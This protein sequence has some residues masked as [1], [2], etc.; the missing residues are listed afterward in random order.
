MI[1]KEV[2]LWT[3]YSVDSISNV[4]M[5]VER[6]K[7]ARV[8]PVRIVRLLARANP[9]PDRKFNIIVYGIMDGTPRQNRMVLQG[10][11]GCVCA[12]LSVCLSSL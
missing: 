10:R 11:I 6:I 4:V 2:L 1:I 12:C 9:D 5:L 7:E 8:C 3:T